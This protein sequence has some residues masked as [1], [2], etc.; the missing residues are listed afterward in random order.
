MTVVII[1]VMTMVRNMSMM[2][3]ILIPAFPPA[4]QHYL[5]HSPLSK[6]LFAVLLARECPPDQPFCFPMT[7]AQIADGDPI[8]Y[9]E[10]KYLEPETAVG[11][12][13]DEVR[14]SSDAVIC[15]VGPVTR[16]FSIGG[17]SLGHLRFSC[18]SDGSINPPKDCYWRS[19]YY[20]ERKY[21]EP[22]T[23]VGPSPD[24]V[25]MSLSCWASVT[26][27]GLVACDLSCE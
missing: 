14:M 3:M 27:R 1:M 8:Y 9:A 26:W 13:P 5:P 7:T 21:L 20:A 4:G 25:M 15:L 16:R 23:A 12:S 24:E 11:P 6:Y 19:I 22:E 17:L 18:L 2:R 10:R